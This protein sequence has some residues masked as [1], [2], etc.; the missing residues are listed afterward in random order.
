MKPNI[1]NSGSRG[2]RFV[3]QFAAEK[4]KTVVAVCLITIMV[5]MW[6]RVIWKKGPQSA[7]AAFT[8]QKV[9]DQT[10]SDIKT[11][12]IE[13]PK[14]QGRNDELSRDFFTVGSWQ[15][16]IEGR[17]NS[18]GTGEVSIVS[19]DSSEEKIRSAAEKLRL[20]AIALGKNPRAFINDKLLSVGDKLYIR[21]GINTYECEVAEI[22]ENMVFLRYGETEVTLRLTQTSTN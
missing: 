18:G 22:E 4:K 7:N 21:E 10:D 2:N 17:E 9:N 12:F 11:T 13:L 19:T 5:F 1:K 16:F 6:V 15:N 14:V 8:T 20:E 3:S